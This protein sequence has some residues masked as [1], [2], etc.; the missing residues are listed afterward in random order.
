M[1]FVKMYNR[2]IYIYLKYRVFK[3]HIYADTIFMLYFICTRINLSNSI[4]ETIIFLHHFMHII[5][6]SFF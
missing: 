3:Q 1:F 4:F 6:I 2:Y 5:L